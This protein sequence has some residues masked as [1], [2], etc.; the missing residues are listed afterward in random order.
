MNVGLLDLSKESYTAFFKKFKSL[1]SHNKENEEI[2]AKNETEL[3]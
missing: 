1:R 3:F 2:R